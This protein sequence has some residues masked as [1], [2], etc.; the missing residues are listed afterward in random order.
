MT[1]GQSAS[2]SDI[3]HAPPGL[4]PPGVDP[5]FQQT[6]R[7]VGIAKSVD[8]SLNWTPSGGF[9][10]KYGN[11]LVGFVNEFVTLRAGRSRPPAVRARRRTHRRASDQRR[12]LRAAHGHPEDQEHHAR[13]T[14][15]T[16][17]LRA[18][19]ADRRRRARRPG[20]G[21]RR[22]RRRRRSRHVARARRRPPDRH[23]GDD[24]PGRDHGGRRGRGRARRRHRA[25]SP[26]SRSARRVATTSTSVFTPTGWCSGSRPVATVVAVL[27]IALDCPRSG[28]RREDARPTQH[29]RP[30]GGWATRAGLPPALAIGSRL[31]VEP[32]RGRRA[33]PV[34]SALIGSIVGV[35]GVVGCFTFRAGLADAAASPQRSGIVWNFVVASGEGSLAPKDVA[36]IT[37]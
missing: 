23:S 2:P 16:A 19:G 27:G 35:L 20:A 13:G 11:R 28:R 14:R 36:A 17:P 9:Y 15:R 37:R 21:A 8:S 1:I 24:T 31:A 30:P 10:A 32:G 7:V 5:N 22:Q 34:R 25:L 12:G 3:A 4:V 29:R 33:V 6:L 18:G 26:L